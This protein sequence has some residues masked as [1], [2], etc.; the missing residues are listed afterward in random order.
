MEVS[1]DRIVRSK[2]IIKACNDFY[3]S[4][5]NNLI[6]ATAKHI[7]KKDPLQS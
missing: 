7:L 1:A 2:S 5:Y 4:W 3:G 6:G